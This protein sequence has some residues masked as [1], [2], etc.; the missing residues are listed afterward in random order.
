MKSYLA[1]S[2]LLA[3]VANQENG[4]SPETLGVIAV[5]NLSYASVESDSD[6]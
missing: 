3:T 4:T 1:K 5:E 2:S 6:G